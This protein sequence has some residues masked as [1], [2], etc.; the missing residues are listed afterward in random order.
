[1]VTDRD[2]SDLRVDELEKARFYD[3]WR[4]DFRLIKD[5][6]VHYVRFGP[7]YY[8]AHL[9]RGK[10]DWKFADDTF[11]ELSR[12]RIKPIG[13][14]VPFR[15]AR[16]DWELPESGMAGLFAQ[17]ARAFAERYEW[18]KLFTPVNEN[19][20]TPRFPRKTAGGTNG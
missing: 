13:G 17:Y 9:G 16:P 12:L 6:G 1:V 7:Q 19:S 8:R 18:V 3:H 11:A 5:I 2:G 4:G 14:L 15:S 10:Y 20:S